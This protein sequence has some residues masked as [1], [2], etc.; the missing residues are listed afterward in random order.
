[1]SDN[2]KE[3]SDEGFGSFLEEN[4]RAVVDFW[5]TWCGPCKAVK[6]T[7][8]DVAGRYKGDI[9]FGEM[10]IE[11]N[12]RVANQYGIQAIPAFLFFE[13]GQVVGQVQGALSM[14]QFIDKIEESF[15]L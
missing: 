7:F 14:D 13:D 2:V 12:N 5:A 15:N 11:E 1:M 9:S 6:P 4:E 8:E 3:L 10:N